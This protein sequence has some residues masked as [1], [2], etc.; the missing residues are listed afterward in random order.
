[1]AYATVNDV[2]ARMTRQ[3][4]QD[5]QAMCSTLL[6]DAAVLIDAAAPDAS[7]D[8]KKVVSCRVVIRAVGNDE[9]VPIGASQGSQSA[10]GYTQ[11]WTM[12]T[13]GSVGELYLAKTDKR[14]LGVGNQVGSYSPVQELV[15]EDSND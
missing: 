2:Q 4:T 11:S 6:D 5:E 12:G 9:G 1:M 14:L 7:A 8:A 3:L 13:G 10:L 15:P